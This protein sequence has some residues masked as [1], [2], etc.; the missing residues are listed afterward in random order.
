MIRQAASLK[1]SYFKFLIL[2]GQKVFVFTNHDPISPKVIVYTSLL[3]KP[4]WITSAGEIESAGEL[5]AI[6]PQTTLVS[7]A[8][9]TLNELSPVQLA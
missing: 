5:E 2:Y 4:S 3:F 7:I 6:G 8:V 1:I 9:G